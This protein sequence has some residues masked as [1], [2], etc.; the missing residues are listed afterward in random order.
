MTPPPRF[1]ANYWQA[2]IDAWERGAFSQR[3][4]PSVAELRH[5]LPGWQ[6]VLR[7][8][9]SRPQHP[10]EPLFEHAPEGLI[11]AVLKV[12]PLAHWRRLFCQTGEQ[13]VLGLRISERPLLRAAW[14]RK[15]DAVVQ[16]LLVPV[17][18]GLAWVEG[19]D[20]FAIGSQAVEVLDE[21]VKENGGNVQDPWH[22]TD[23]GQAAR[24]RAL[25]ERVDAWFAAGMPG[26]HT[27]Q[28]GV[29]GKAARLVQAPDR[30]LKFWKALVRVGLSGPQAQQAWVD[31]VPGAALRPTLAWEVM[32]RFYTT[33][34]PP[35]LP[36]PEVP[37]FIQTLLAKP[38]ASSSSAVGVLTAQDVVG[39]LKRLRGKTCPP[40]LRAAL[41]ESIWRL[42]E[43]AAQVSRGPGSWEASTEQALLFEVVQWDLPQV[44]D[45]S[46]APARLAAWNGLD[47]SLSAAHTLWKGWWLGG[48]FEQ[49]SGCEAWTQLA[50]AQD[51]RHVPEGLARAAPYQLVEALLRGGRQLPPPEALVPMWT[52]AVAEALACSPVQAWE[53]LDAE[54]AQSPA[55]RKD[56]DKIPAAAQQALHRERARVQQGYLEAVIPESPTKALR[57]RL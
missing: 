33:L 27:A 6:P 35:T 45:P 38:W 52:R 15:Q 23:A 54:L 26:K 22:F 1:D 14:R 48:G 12:R 39:P 7:S 50:V 57:L 37:A 30:R 3:V 11:Q 49:A 19:A 4:L 8:G 10:L 43:V 51:L 42:V 55:L 32:E 53:R 18:Q 29:E 40:P 2:I 13:S 16:D 41:L 25:W 34:A 9:T 5:P 44:Q 28:G 46:L 36:Q 31:A 17:L 21:L 20:R 56:C 24:M 47:W